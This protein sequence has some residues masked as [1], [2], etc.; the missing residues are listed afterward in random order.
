MA[1]PGRV[2]F[3]VRRRDLDSL[4]A[5]FRR[6]YSHFTVYPAG[7]RTPRHRAAARGRTSLVPGAEGARPAVGRP[8]M[9]EMREREALAVPADAIAPPNGLRSESS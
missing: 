8:G 6:V 4:R 2:R 5:G 9:E 3:V 7:G 1:S